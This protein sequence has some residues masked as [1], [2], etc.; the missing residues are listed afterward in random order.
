MVALQFDKFFPVFVAKSP[1][2]PQYRVEQ[3]SKLGEREKLHEHL[4]H[5][6]VVLD[7]VLTLGKG[8]LRHTL[9]IDDKGGEIHL[10]RA[11][12]EKVRERL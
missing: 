11:R 10:R 4:Y 5:R 2:L 3:R 1:V 9:K 12:G 6:D 7:L 8:L